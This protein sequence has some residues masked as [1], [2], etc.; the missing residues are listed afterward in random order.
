MTGTRF[1]IIILFLTANS[2]V[3]IDDYVVR[4]LQKYP[5]VECGQGSNGRLCVVR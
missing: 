3:D 2:G 4:D 1:L 5:L